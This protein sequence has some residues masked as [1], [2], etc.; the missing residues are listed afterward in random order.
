MAGSKADKILISIDKKLKGLRIELG[1]TSFE[2]FVN[3]F[4][5]NRKQ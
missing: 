2:T 4:E 1:N 3:D 5:L